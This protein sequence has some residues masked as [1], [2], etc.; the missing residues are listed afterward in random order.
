MKNDSLTPSPKSGAVLAVYKRPWPGATEERLGLVK[1]ERVTP[2][3]QIVVRARRYDSGGRQIGALG[4]QSRL[5]LRWPTELD[6]AD[7]R[8]VKLVN[9]LRDTPWGRQTDEI[10]EAAAKLLG[11]EVT[12]P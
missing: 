11:I 5:H 6:R 10:L 3:G 12:E 8:R 4:S 1:V 9:A 2:T 7:H